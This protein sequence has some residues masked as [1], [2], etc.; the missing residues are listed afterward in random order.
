M[1]VPVCR[2][3]PGKFVNFSSDLKWFELFFSIL[4]CSYYHDF[5]PTHYIVDVDSADYCTL[6]LN[7]ADSLYGITFLK[8]F[9]FFQPNSDIFLL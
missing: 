3:H 5:F 9:T 2:L 7:H 6:P 8:Y 4:H 1:S